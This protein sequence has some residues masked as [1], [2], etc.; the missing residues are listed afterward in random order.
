MGDGVGSGGGVDCLGDGV[1]VRAGLLK[2]WRG[3]FNSIDF[4]CAGGCGYEGI[5]CSL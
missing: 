3:G 2:G 1:V 5:G 4:G